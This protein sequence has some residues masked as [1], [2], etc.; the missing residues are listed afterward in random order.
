MPQLRD[1]LRA[2]E[3]DEGIR[4]K[5]PKSGFRIFISKSY[6][7]HYTIQLVDKSARKSVSRDGSVKYLNSVNDVLLL[8]K[9]IFKEEVNYDIY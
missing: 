1:I 2:L 6:S 3:P 9:S 8:I 7:G 4:I 5:D